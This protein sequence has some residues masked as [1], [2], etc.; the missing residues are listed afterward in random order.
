MLTPVRVF[1][2]LIAL[3]IV[4][5]LVLSAALPAG[6]LLWVGAGLG[7]LGA[8]FG[9]PAGLIYH[10]RLWRSL[11]RNGKSTAGFWLR[12]MALHAELDEA[13]RAMIQRWFAIGAVG[14]G[15]TMLGALGVV[16]AIVR[17]LT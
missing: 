10:A 16:I 12:P 15:V 8:S 7:T 17:L 13:D 3:L 5:A 2:A 14:F 1:E 11:R 6:W 9:V 4:L